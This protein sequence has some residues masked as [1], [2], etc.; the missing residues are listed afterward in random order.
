MYEFFPNQAAPLT[1][2]PNTYWREQPL[3]ADPFVVSFREVQHRSN[4]VVWESSR[5]HQ[6]KECNKS[7]F[8]AHA[9]YFFRPVHQFF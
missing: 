6:E 8:W 9:Y 1:Q 7:S 4:G 2:T 3:H 5:S